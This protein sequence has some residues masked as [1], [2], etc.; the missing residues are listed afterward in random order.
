MNH[1]LNASWRHTIR[2]MEFEHESAELEDIG[3]G[4]ALRWAIQLSVSRVSRDCSNQGHERLTYVEPSFPHVYSNPQ[5]YS[6]GR[7]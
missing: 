5:L 2:S 4:L 6:T 7:P 1:V 3:Q